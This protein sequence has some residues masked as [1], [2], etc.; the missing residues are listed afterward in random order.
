MPRRPRI[1]LPGVPIHLVQ[2][3]HNREA[4]FYSDEDFLAYREWLGD[5]LRKTG[6]ALHAYV[7]MTNHVHLLLTSP[8]PEAVSQ[9]VMSLGRRYVQYI[10]KIYRRTGTLWDSRY[11]SSLVH[12]D[13]YLLLCQRYI[14]LNPVRADMTDDPALYRWSSYRANG[15]GQADAL[16]TPHDLYL[17]L[18]GNS[19]N[20][21]AVY[22]SLFRSEL[23][24]EA[25]ADIRLALNQGQPLGKG[26]FLDQVENMLGRRCEVRPRGRPSKMKAMSEAKDQ[27]LALPM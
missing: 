17:A 24:H 14:E 5:A 11:K 19:A 10:N 12:A 26:R 25:L 4:C 22:R 13:D 7:L 2:R 9:L 23:D 15:L 21:Q 18:D 1:H 3:G 6:C 20:R 27:Q 8:S 16:L